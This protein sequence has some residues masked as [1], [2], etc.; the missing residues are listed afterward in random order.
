MREERWG[1]DRG[2]MGEKAVNMILTLTKQASYLIDKLIVSLK[3]KHKTEGGLREKLY[4]E[5]TQYRGY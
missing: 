4:R 5:R 1:L 2:N 3:E